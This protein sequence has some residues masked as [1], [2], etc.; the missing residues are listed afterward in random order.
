MRAL[1]LGLTSL[2]H[3][4]N[5]YAS[6]TEKLDFCAGEH[7]R[8]SGVVALDLLEP[9]LLGSSFECERGKVRNEISGVDQSARGD[10]NV[11]G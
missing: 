2:C 8:R 11:L 6:N 3:L 5:T 10:R 1:A 7:E 4:G 9:G